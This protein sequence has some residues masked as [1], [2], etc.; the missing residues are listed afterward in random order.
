MLEAFASSRR[1][2]PISCAGLISD[3]CKTR[4][5]FCCQ[6]PRIPDSLNSKKW[7]L[8]DQQV[9]RMISS[10]NYQGNSSNWLLAKLQADNVI[11]EDDEIDSDVLD[12]DSDDDDEGAISIQSERANNVLLGDT[13]RAVPQERRGGVE[14]EVPDSERVA[15]DEDQADDS[16]EHEEYRH[17][18]QS[19]WND[20]EDDQTADED[21][22]YEPDSA[23]EEVVREDGDEEDDPNIEDDNVKVN[24]K[25]LRELVND[26]WLTIA[27][28]QLGDDEAETAGT[29]AQQSKEQLLDTIRAATSRAVSNSVLSTLIGQL[30]TG[31]KLSEMCIDGLAVGA[32]RKIVARQIT[33]A[34]QLLLEILLRAG[35]YTST[36][37]CASDCLIKLS[38]FREIASKKVVLMQQNMRNVSLLKHIKPDNGRS[39]KEMMDTELF[40]LMHEVAGSKAVSAPPSSSAAAPIEEAAGAQRFTRS[41]VMRF[42]KQYQ[43]S[44]SLFDIPVLSRITEVMQQIDLC[45]KAIAEATQTMNTRTSLTNYPL[46]LSRDNVA[47]S[48][49]A[50]HMRSHTMLAICG[51]QI[52]AL[53]ARFNMRLW[54]CLVPTATYP[55]RE[56][57]QMSLDPLSIQGRSYFSPAE[58]DLLLR[59]IV[60]LGDAQ[61]WSDIKVLFL[62]SKDVSVLQFQ[63]T[64]KTMITVSTMQNN[65]KRYQQLMADEKN[66][67]GKDEPWGLLDDFFLLKGFEVFGN[68]WGMHVLFYLPHRKQDDIKN[69]WT[70]LQRTWQRAFPQQNLHT[71]QLPITPDMQQFL[72]NLHRCHTIHQVQN[73]VNGTPAKTADSE[74][75]EVDANDALDALCNQDE[76]SMVPSDEDTHDNDHDDAY[77]SFLQTR[78]ANGNVR[79]DSERG[80]MN[81][82]PPAFSTQS[83]EPFTFGNHNS[84]ELRLPSLRSYQNMQPPFMPNPLDLTFNASSTSPHNAMQAFGQNGYALPPS[85]MFSDPETSVHSMNLATM[86]AAAINAQAMQHNA[87]PPS[88]GRQ[89]LRQLPN[90]S[91]TLAPA[92][93]SMLINKR[94]QGDAEVQSRGLPKKRR[95]A[96]T[97][98]NPSALVSNSDNQQKGINT[99]EAGGASMGIVSAIHPKSTTEVGSSSSVRHAAVAID[100]PP[101]NHAAPIGEGG[102]AFD[103]SMLM[104]DLSLGFTNLTSM[105]NLLKEGTQQ[106]NTHADAGHASQGSLECYSSSQDNSMASAL[107]AANTQGS[108][109]PTGLFASV[110]RGNKKR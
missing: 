100:Q 4:K 74:S 7:P 44:P 26:C 106:P 101:S 37:N 77:L 60:A 107:S 59:G 48:Q 85:N 71:T 83:S 12:D 51:D 19:I 38:N 97:L 31:N 91:L 61:K 54:R 69:R 89:P 45:R 96:T 84:M 105:L 72:L 1:S 21:E 99:N 14:M 29:S 10:H 53:H 95:V 18:L 13:Y 93:S 46:L 65:F 3:L 76:Q 50:S 16:V 55:I 80:S 27:G 68:K 57:A 79:P 86:R 88:K 82:P 23:D 9:S 81:P 90:P 78:L 35:P 5:Y 39:S 110:M 6:I 2:D 109:D 36:F 73:M 22:D 92:P 103:S 25:E 20:D 102:Y 28:Q 47:S 15:M 104:G 94:N 11:R 30:F 40:R 49:T 8:I 34:F 52:A 67:R 43:R 41:D 64:Q 70:L 32:I 24:K 87:A 17:F 58:D 75:A 63:F 33:M 108:S 56:F 98:I 66:A 42:N 62:P